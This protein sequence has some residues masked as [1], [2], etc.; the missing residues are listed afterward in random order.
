MLKE[1]CEMA[2]KS[3]GKGKREDI[4]KERADMCK[5]MIP[6]GTSDFTEIRKE[7]FYYVDK[8]GMIA[9]LMKTSGTKVTLITRP[10]RFGKT[11]GMSMLAAFFDIRQDSRELFEGLEISKQTRLCAEWMNQYPTLFLSLK[12]VDGL[13]FSG[14]YGRLTSVI[15]KTYKEHLYLLDS[16]KINPY[17]KE[18]FQRIAAKK[19]TPEEIKDSLFMLTRMLEAYY[20]KQVILLIDEYDVPLA[21]A[22]EK[23]Y[24]PEMLDMLKGLM[25]TF[26]D[27]SS[28][29]FAVITGCLRI[30]KESIF[31]GTN[32]FVANTV[33]DT[34]RKSVV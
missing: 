17:D 34:D 7:G 11:L 12:S 18:I 3:S 13:D 15:A 24:Y 16:D 31:T 30:A 33:S 9:E 28:L 23:G 19:P 29:K 22:S 4:R 25:Q 26:K 20:E 5:I 1:L 2:V 27:N 8:S 21:K 6:V 10:R 14:A 32:N